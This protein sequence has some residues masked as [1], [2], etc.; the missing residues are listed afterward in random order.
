MDILVALAIGLFIV[1][2]SVAVGGTFILIV[3][4]IWMCFLEDA[5]KAF[6]RAAI[7]RANTK[8]HRE[9][10]RVFKDFMDKHKKELEALKNESKLQRS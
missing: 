1:L 10:I 9:Q 3:T 4:S 5:F 6:R 7:E 2:L 8:K